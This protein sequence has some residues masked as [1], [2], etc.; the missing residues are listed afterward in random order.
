MVISKGSQYKFAILAV[1][2]GVTSKSG[3]KREEI[4]RQCEQSL[5]VCD[6]D[7]KRIQK[8]GGESGRGSLQGALSDLKK[9]RLI[10]KPDDILPE[11]VITEK[12]KAELEELAAIVN[13]AWSTQP[14]SLVLTEKACHIA[15]VFL[16]VAFEKEAVLI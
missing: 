3:V 2:S 16:D 5:V 1:I 9:N 14:E 6:E 12:G 4:F 11:Y 13:E 7:Y 15:A 8:S 10:H